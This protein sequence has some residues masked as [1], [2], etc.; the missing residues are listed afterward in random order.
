[1]PPAG[2]GTP[3]CFAVFANSST[4]ACTYTPNRCYFIVA[5]LLLGRKSNSGRVDETAC[6]R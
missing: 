4:T 2:M 1:M 6:I 3:P 5:P